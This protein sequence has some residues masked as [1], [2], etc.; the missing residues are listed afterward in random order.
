[1]KPSHNCGVALQYARA[2]LRIFPCKQDKRPLDGLSWPKAATTDE[3]QITAW[4]QHDPHALIGLPLKQIDC[5]VIDAD[6]HKPDEDGVEM[7]HTLREGKELPPHPIIHTANNGEH[8]YFKQRADRKIGNQ[9]IDSGL[10]TRGFKPENDGGYVIAAGSLAADGRAWRLQDGAPSLLAMLKNGGLHEAPVWLVAEIMRP[11]SKGVALTPNGGGIRPQAE[12]REAEYAQAAL[13]RCIEDLARAQTGERNNELNRAAYA[14]GQ[15][16]ARNWLAQ[17]EV[18]DGLWG[19]SVANG[20][21]RD[22]GAD[23]VQK[24]LASG[25]EAG[26]AEPHANLTDRP[27]NGRGDAGTGTQPKTE[28]PQGKRSAV[29]ECAADIKAEAVEWLWPNR[30]ALGN[31]TLIGG[32]PGVGK[33]QLTTDIVARVTTGASW[34]NAEGKAPFGSVI[35]LSAEDNAK[36]T[37]VPRLIAAGANLKRVHIY[38]M[39]RNEDGSQRMFSLQT[40]LDVL[41]EVIGRFGDTKLVVIDPVSSYFGTGKVDSHKNTDVRGVLDPL[42][43]LAERA[44]VA[45]LSVTHPPTAVSAEALT[46]YMGSQAFVAMARSAYLVI[47]EWVDGRETERRLFCCAKSNLGRKVATLAYRLLQRFVAEE[48]VP[49]GI[50]ISSI[51]WEPGTIDMTADQALAAAS[52]TTESRSAKAEATE[53][54]RDAL[55]SGPVPAER[56]QEQAQEDGIAPRTLR[57]ARKDLGVIIEKDGFQGP[58]MWCLPK[59]GQETPKVAN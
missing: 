12:S 31:Q 4:W 43:K 38:Q 35:I 10:E 36:N 42:S 16:V 40:D 29:I 49:G 6:R 27:F 1:M 5:F 8:W 48:E 44:N 25:L 14:L 37:I 13:V 41:E 7:L 57:R 45:I 23:S 11:R 24:T 52:G 30:I 33:S 58:S 22:D 34:P 54:L 21:V 50:L 2:G 3:Q 51:E 26:L 59:G 9:K 46:R 55:A 18:V 17:R 28:Q 53:F 20:L 19:A 47:E 15:L 32:N 39:T 56:V